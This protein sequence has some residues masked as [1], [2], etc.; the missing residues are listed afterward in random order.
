MPATNQ[1]FRA[2]KAHFTSAP[3]LRVPNPDHQ[4]V[5]EVDA[6]DLGMGEVLSQRSTYWAAG[7]Q[8][9][10]ILVVD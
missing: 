7:L 10:T 3:I 9:T 6:S 4:F 8:L 1:A 2:L 5:V